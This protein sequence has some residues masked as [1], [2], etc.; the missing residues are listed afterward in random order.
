MKENKKGKY[1]DILGF[2]GAG[3]CGL[4]VISGGFIPF[5]YSVILFLI[6]VL[7]LFLYTFILKK[8]KEI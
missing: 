6:G 3:L 8:N 1:L 5:I 7:M 2:S 4:G